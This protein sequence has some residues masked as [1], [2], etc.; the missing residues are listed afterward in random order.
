MAETSRPPMPAE[1][2]L[3]FTDAVVAI[4]I[5]LLILPLLEAVAEAGREHMTAGEFFNVN[6][7]QIAMFLISF[8]VILAFWTA[9]HGAFLKVKA[10]SWRVVYLDMAWVLTIVW[11]PVATALIG[12]LPIDRIQAVSYVGTMALTSILMALMVLQIRSSPHL[13]KEGDGPSLGAFFAS[14]SLAL[15]AVIALGVVLIV[16]AFGL[17]PMCLMWFTPL[18][19]RLMRRAYERRRAVASS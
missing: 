18:V 4:A 19:E 15:L 3:A 14:V 2:L 8:V 12:A 11:M 17:L 5:T 10:V 1:R 13:W 7:T 9:H 16:P 6:A